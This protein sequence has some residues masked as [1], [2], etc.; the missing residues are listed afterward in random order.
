MKKE[1]LPLIVIG[2]TLLLFRVA[3]AVL[4]NYP[5]LAQIPFNSAPLAAF[6]F[7]GV[8]FSG[9]VGMWICSVLFLIS[10]PLLSLIKGYGIGWD[11]PVSVLGFALIMLIALKG[12]ESGFQQGRKV[13]LIVGGSIVCAVSFYFLTN[14]M[15]WLTLPQ[16]YEKSLTGFYHAQWGQAPTLPQPTWMFLRNSL[17]GNGLFAVLISLAHWKVN[18]KQSLAPVPAVN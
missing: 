17:T 1:Y 14:T 5:E 7:C 2:L 16:H 15:S 13:A 12:R 9:R 4:P 6:F 18:F 10:Y 11:F 3:Q 8:L